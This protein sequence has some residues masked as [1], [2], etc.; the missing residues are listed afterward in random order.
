MGEINRKLLLKLLLLL[1][2]SSCK[3]VEKYNKQVY[4]L[5]QPK[6]LHKDIDY[7]YKKLHRLHPE[8]HWYV[9]KDSLDLAFES[10]KKSINKPMTS[11]EFF[12]KFTVTAWHILA[13][14]LLK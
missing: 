5:H 7:A 8:I 11:E 14:N 10:L 6:D 3:S 9:S 12:M 4:G 2:L 13:R 1:L